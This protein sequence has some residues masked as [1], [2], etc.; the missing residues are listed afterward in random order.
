MA[1][2]MARSG[3]S[4]GLAGLLLRAGERA[5]ARSSAAASVGASSSAARGLAGDATDAAQQPT[6]VTKAVTKEYLD[7]AR[8]KIFGTYPGNGLRSG[9]KILR[10]NL[11]G[12]KVL[13]WYPQTEPHAKVHKGDK[14]W[15]DPDLWTA[16]ERLERYKRRGKGPPKKGA[17]KRAT[18]K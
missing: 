18:R 4:A 10:K 6:K 12:D 5:L 9:R 2:T 17:G 11:V 8:W 14:L 15:D 16:K 7:E 13:A 3:T 1:T